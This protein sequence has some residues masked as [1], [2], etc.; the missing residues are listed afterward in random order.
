MST[1][2]AIPATVIPPQTPIS[3]PT[4]TANNPGP[5]LVLFSD[6]N[7]TI[8]FYPFTAKDGSPHPSNGEI[9]IRTN[10]KPDNIRIMLGT[11][12]KLIASINGT[13]HELPFNSTGE[14]QFM[15][16]ATGAGNDKI[17]I[18]PLVTTNITIYSGEGDDFITAGGGQ[19]AVFGG[20]GNDYIR[21]G[22]G[23]GV[24]YGGEGADVMVAGTGNASMSG[25]KGDD[26]LYA[27]Y[28]PTHL[29][30]VFLNGD[31]GRDELYAGTGIT[32]LNGGLDDDKLVGHHQTTFYTGAGKDTVTSYSARDKIYAK[33]N[34]VIHNAANV[35]VTHIQPVDSGKTVFKIEG[36]KRFVAIV[37]AYIEQLRG[38][39]AGQQMLKKLDSLAVKNGGPVVIKKSDF[40][41]V[42]YYSFKNSHTD[43][44]P[45]GQHESRQQTPEFGYIKNGISGSPATHAEINFR[46]TEF[47][48]EPL[49]AAPLV[50]LYHE[51]AHAFNGA[52]GTFIPGSQPILGKD[53]N[54]V[55]VN[56]KPA[57]VDNLEYQAVG[58]PTDAPPFDF[59][60]D[61]LTPPT[62]TNPPPFTE[63]ALR[64]EMGIPLRDR[65][66]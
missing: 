61:P 40:L 20:R 53:G 2:T 6:A 56:G 31:E 36:N 51:M 49:P 60:N 38:S 21:L 44:I 16:I 41:G 54:P 3:P 14:L 37:E 11:N 27:M 15:S 43:K 46:P 42:N 50:A 19:T 34:D 57:A 65:Y 58:L 33:E 5:T 29:R 18:D 13:C 25:G 23:R 48:D 52:T 12:D 39:P 9:T 62:T 17:S 28:P 22:S 26:K 24:A 10:D 59:D 47:A 7:T 4:T 35:P 30:Q 32:V 45:K 8:T 64:A 63:N 55:I 66:A 1:V